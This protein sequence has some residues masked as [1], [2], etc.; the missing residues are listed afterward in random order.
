M[1]DTAPRPAVQ[2]TAGVR[3]ALAISALIFGVIVVALLFNVFNGDPSASGS[4]T[5]TPAATSTTIAELAPIDVLDAECS[6]EGLGSFVC[7]NL[8]DG[9]EGEYQFDYDAVP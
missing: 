4:S 6:Q 8:I 2:A 5:T 9:T 7:E 1:S 3:A